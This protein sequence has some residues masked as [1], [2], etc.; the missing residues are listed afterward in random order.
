[1]SARDE[2]KRDVARE[3]AI[4]RARHRSYLRDCAEVQAIDWELTPEQ[5]AWLD[6]QLAAEDLAAEAAQMLKERT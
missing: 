5:R 4:L 1:M 3:L 6:E 2:I